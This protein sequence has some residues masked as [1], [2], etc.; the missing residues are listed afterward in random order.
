MSSLYKAVMVA[1]ATLE[2]VLQSLPVETMQATKLKTFAEYRRAVRKQYGK[3]AQLFTASIAASMIG[4][5]GIFL[6]GQ[7]YINS[8]DRRTEL[9]TVKVFDMEL[10]EASNTYEVVVD[11]GAEGSAFG[12]REL[13]TGSGQ[14]PVFIFLRRPEG[15]EYTITAAETKRKVVGA[16]A[17]LAIEKL[18]SSTPR[19]DR[20]IETAVDEEVSK[21]E[22]DR[23][24]NIAIQRIANSLN[25]P[26][27]KRAKEP[28]NRKTKE[29]LK[30]MVKGCMLGMA[31]GSINVACLTALG[32]STAVII[33]TLP[34]VTA[35]S[36]LATTKYLIQ[37][38]V[39]RTRRTVK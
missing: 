27:R 28:N 12:E 29:I 39:L 23:S 7:T 4:K 6:V 9:K 22:A 32:Y 1:L 19:L 10:V 17:K 24:S 16:V 33:T 3:H 21:G 35:V 30:I 36:G 8:T 34:I 14:D 2:E 5:T 31:I 26:G 20:A 11:L 13:G 15:E 37:R 38:L 25:V 18:Q